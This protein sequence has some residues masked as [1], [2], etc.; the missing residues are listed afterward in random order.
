MNLTNLA[1][2]LGGVMVGAIFGVVIM[3]CCVVSGNN[4]RDDE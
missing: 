4:R 1:W 3:A 2:F